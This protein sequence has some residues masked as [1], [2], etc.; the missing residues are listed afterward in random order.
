MISWVEGDLENYQG[1]LN[2]IIFLVRKIV[3]SLSKTIEQ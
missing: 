3:R 2:Y 1:F